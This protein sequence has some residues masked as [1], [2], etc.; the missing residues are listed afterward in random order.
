MTLGAH[1]LPPLGLGLIQ[2]D[3]AG[4]MVIMR[5]AGSW[6]RL[7]PSEGVGAQ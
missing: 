5:T 3:I 2:R 4:V 6:Y 7:P 1:R